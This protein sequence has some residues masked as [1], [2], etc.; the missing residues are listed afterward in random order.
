MNG[1]KP[2]NILADQEYKPAIEVNTDAF[3]TGST[4]PA[5]QSQNP[6]QN[7]IPNPIQNQTQNP[8][9]EM[10]KDPGIQTD[11]QKALSGTL[12]KIIPKGM[13]NG[14]RV[15]T[16]ER[17]SSIPVTDLNKAFLQKP[18]RTYEGDIAE[19]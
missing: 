6:T 19:I 4:N 9:K 3:K 11:L 17:Y 7:P 10:I 12:G 5:G 15:Q 18:I 14:D 16:E 8:P 13:N 1:E 2:L